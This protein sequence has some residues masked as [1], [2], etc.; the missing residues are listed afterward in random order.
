MFR[1]LFSP[2]MIGLHLLAIAATA[3]AVLLGLWQYGVWQSARQ[4]KANVLAHA[5]PVPLSTL[6]TADSP[7][8]GDAVGRPVRFAGTWLPGETLLVQNRLMHGERGYWAVTPVAVC[9]ATCTSSDPAMLVVRGWTSDPEQVPAAPRGRVRVTGWLQP[10]EGGGAPDQNPRDR[11]LPQMEVVD[12]IP[13]V[14]QDLYSGYVIA[15]NASSGALRPVTP[16]SLPKP[17]D[18][19]SLRNLAYAFQWWIFGAFA[20]FLWF[21]W[22]SD[23][24]KRVTEADQA[25]A[26]DAADS[27]EEPTGA[28]GDD[29][30]E[31]PSKS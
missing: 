7:Y 3:A 18:L 19:T 29:R 28:R 2:L 13:H 14:R 1:A 26:A 4:E 9:R 21:R 11:V 24:V 8:P 30:R 23:E 31:V 12:A 10:A 15:Q 5:A 27:R 25:A 22:C 16:A 17:S 20:V 6:M